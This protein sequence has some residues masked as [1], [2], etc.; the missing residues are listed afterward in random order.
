MV[1]VARRQIRHSGLFVVLMGIALIILAVATYSDSK[2]SFFPYFFG[3]MGC[4]LT[5]FGVLRLSRK[6]QFPKPDEQKP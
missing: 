2:D 3:F 5:A 6:E 1:A 4:L